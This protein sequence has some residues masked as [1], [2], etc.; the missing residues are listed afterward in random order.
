[1]S[2]KEAYT[3]ILRANFLKYMRVAFK[4]LPKMDKPRILD[5][6]CGTGIPTIEL[7]NL[8][9]GDIIAIDIDQKLIETLKEKI[10]ERNL[11]T[12][13]TAK[14]MSFLKNDFSDNYFD[15]IWEESVLQVIGFRKS[16]KECHRVL[17]PGGFLVHCQSINNLRKNHDFIINSGFKIV[18]QLNLPEDCWWTEYYEP[19]EK[20]LKDIREGKGDK[21]LFRDLNNV[22]VEIKMVKSNPKE[23]DCGYYILQKGGI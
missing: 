5:P 20:K 19:L 16:F 1:M 21:N 15:L 12:R 8:S 7:A 9:D 11:I 10:K 2:Y 3:E 4:L 6:G 17:K 13:I 14:K 18:N 23:Y 22:E